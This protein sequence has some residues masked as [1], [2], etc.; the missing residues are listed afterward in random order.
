MKKTFHHTGIHV[1]RDI[2]GTKW[3]H[4]GEVSVNNPG[5]NSQRIE[6]IY[7]RPNTFAPGTE[8]EAHIAYTVDDLDA[9]IEGKE[10][11][12]APHEMGGFCRAAFTRED[13][14]QVEYIQLHPGR[15]WFDDEV[16]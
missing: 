9:A 2:P 3:T 6:W 16:R 15:S 10:I 5:D 13:G 11:V 4:L 8:W 12:I 7:H 14:L 1:T